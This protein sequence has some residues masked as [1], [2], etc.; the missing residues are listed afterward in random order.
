MSDSEDPPKNRNSKKRKNTDPE[1]NK[2]KNGMNM[3][4]ITRYELGR[5]FIWRRTEMEPL[6]HH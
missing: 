2:N 6:H 3:P 5:I 4:I 1:K